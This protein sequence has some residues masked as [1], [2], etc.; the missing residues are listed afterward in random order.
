VF[1]GGG[2]PYGVASITGGVLSDVTL[3]RPLGVSYFLAKWGV[4][5]VFGPTGTMGNNGAVTWGTALTNALTGGAWVVMPAGS[6]AAGVPAAT[7]I[8]WYVGTNTTTGTFFNSTINLASPGT[9]GTTTA[10]A[11]TGPG[12]FTGVTAQTTIASITLPANAL[13]A[14]GILFAELDWE[15][16]NNANAKSGNFIVGSTDFG[17]PMNLASAATLVA[18]MSIRAGATTGKQYSRA[19]ILTGAGAPNV[20][21]VFGSE[22]LTTQL[23]ILIK[24]SR[25]G[26]ATD[27]VILYGASIS[28]AN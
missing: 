21:Q 22:D 19:V 17:S 9:V 11:T 8:L 20:T 18:R 13:T 26:A 3:T 5:I 6:I 14:S 25:N 24:A 12:A 27:V 23:T 28:V 1:R 16:T 10:Y 15:A 2:G 4:P 7:A